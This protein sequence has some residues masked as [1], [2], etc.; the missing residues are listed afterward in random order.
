MEVGFSKEVIGFG[1]L[2]KKLSNKLPAIENLG[3]LDFTVCLGDL[4]NNH[5]FCSDYNL[6][7]EKQPLKFE[8]DKKE[9]KWE[10]KYMWSVHLDIKEDDTCSIVTK[11]NKPSNVYFKYTH[12][13]L[14]DYPNDEEQIAQILK[15]YFNIDVITIDEIEATINSHPTKKEFNE[16]LD[17]RIKTV[18]VDGEKLIE[19]IEC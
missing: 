5:E 19:T 3:Y 9:D 14:N 17:E 13:D 16:W 1:E 8:L 18:V 2:F 10:I 7:A 15:E 11:S 12:V 4:S 6:H